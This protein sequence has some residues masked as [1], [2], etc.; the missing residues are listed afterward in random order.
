MKDT[1]KLLD[2]SAKNEADAA[3]EQREDNA[4][5]GM[6][7]E[8]FWKGKDITRFKSRSR[9]ISTMRQIIGNGFLGAKMLRAKALYEGAWRVVERRGNA[10]SSAV[11]QRLIDGTK[12]G[13]VF[14]VSHSPA[15]NLDKSKFGG[16]GGDDDMGGKG[17]T[18]SA[19]ENEQKSDGNRLDMQVFTVRIISD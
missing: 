3:D 17:I 11:D 14:V 16:D 13:R 5:G 2:A 10:R 4:P 1:I 19:Q 12:S 15:W 7:F 6:P 18:N 8:S 9:R